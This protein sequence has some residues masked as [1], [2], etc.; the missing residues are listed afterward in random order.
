MSIRSTVKAV[1]IHDGKVLLNKC[2]RHGE[3]YYNLPGGGQD[4]YEDMESAVRREVMEETGYT[5]ENMSFVGLYEDIFM[6]DKLNNNDSPYSHRIY[7][8]FAATIKTDERSEAT[9]FDADMEK[10]EW[11]DADEVKSLPKVFP[12]RL[13]EIVD[14]I[15]RGGAPMYPGTNF[16]ENLKQHQMSYQKSSDYD[17]KVHIKNLL[18]THISM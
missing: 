18:R 8:I 9:G 17:V 16:T 2:V 7:H 6:D 12:E 10:S 4:K 13:A 14:N 3:I 11:V 5:V 15:I 1:I